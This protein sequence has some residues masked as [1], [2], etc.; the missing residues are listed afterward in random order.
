MTKTAAETTTKTVAETMTTVATTMM[1]AAMM[2]K[3]MI[4]FQVVNKIIH[5][6][7]LVQKV[8]EFLHR[9]LSKPPLTMVVL[10]ESGG[11]LQP[12]LPLLSSQTT[13]HYLP[14]LSNARLQSDTLIKHHKQAL[15]QPGTE[16]QVTC[17]DAGATN[18]NDHGILL[19]NTMVVAQP[20]LTTLSPRH[21]ATIHSCNGLFSQSPHTVTT[22]PTDSPTHHTLLHH[23]QTK[24]TTEKEFTM[25]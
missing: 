2:T 7:C 22:H 11:P 17:F 20:F 12:P 4:Q 6:I 25:L 23:N 1:S 5:H 16:L 18:A 8:H 14:P 15:C 24:T 9:K 3:E 21:M 19:H 10:E 13:S